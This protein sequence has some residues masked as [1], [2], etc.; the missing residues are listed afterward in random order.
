MFAA[1]KRGISGKLAVAMLMMALVAVLLVGCGDPDPGDAGYYAIESLTLDGEAYD[2]EAL[3]EV[4]LEYYIILHE[5]GTADINVDALVTGTWEKGLLQ[6][7]EDGEVI[8]LEFIRDGDTLTIEVADEES[9]VIYLFKRGEAPAG[10]AKGDGHFTYEELEEIYTALKESYDALELRELD[11]EGV[12]DAFFD[13]IDGAL[14]FEGDYT[15]MYKWNAAD[16]DEAYVE[17][18]FSTDEEGDSDRMADGIRTYF[19]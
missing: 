13:G 11:Y 9:E 18:S 19:P 16:H 3:R 14:D 5:D 7:E 2:A 12:R 6:Y 1:G 8:E 15:T 17:V 4:G 10:L